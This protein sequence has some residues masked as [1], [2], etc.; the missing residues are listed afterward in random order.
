M[1]LPSRQR[2]L[3]VS[4]PAV[5]LLSACASSP[6][7]PDAFV[8]SGVGNTLVNAVSY[9]LDKTVYWGAWAAAAYLILDPLA[10]NWEV[11][12][13]RFPDD[14][15]HLELLMKRYYSGGAGEARLVFQ[16]R[17]KELMRAGGFKRYVVVEYAE[18]MDS[19]MLGS[20]R[21][22]SGVIRLLP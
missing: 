11:H 4:L 2:R 19:S 13:A 9:P 20:Q 14:H 16:R 12:E 8:A 21:T 22:A 10:P 1:K 5:F 7:S 3:L 15:V 18:G 6:G 17:A